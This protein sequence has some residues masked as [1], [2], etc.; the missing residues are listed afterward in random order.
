MPDKKRT[1]PPLLGAHFSVAGG[2]EKA[3]SRAHDLSC[4]ALQIFTKNARSWAEPMPEK[5]T[6]ES[7]QRAISETG[8]V[9]AASHC[10]YLI[11]I[12][13]PEAEKRSRSAASLLAELK[14]SALLGLDAV[15]LHPGS[16]LGR[17][18]DQGL[19]TA[20]QTLKEVRANAP[21]PCP[22][23]LLETTAGTG[24]SIGSR[25]E[26]LAAILERL[27]SSDGTGICLDTSHI[28]AAGYDLR[29][30]QAFDATLAEFDRVIGLDRLFLIHAN[31]SKT[32][33]GS[34][35]DRHEHIGKGE[36]GPTSFAHLMQHPELC[37][38]PKILET[39]KTLN[40][41]DMDPVN[42]GMLLSLAD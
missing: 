6:V 11:N 31:D 14:R 34:K 15:V 4:R 42:L 13:S 25:F 33:L 16:H 36:M 27:T 18:M 22:R 7:F 3:V 5:K 40:E 1:G 9:F 28:F 12:A 26:E 23:L 8:M 2:L 29:T 41:R 32:P 19:Q 24:T 21:A 37:A 10:S 20:A 38:I 17:G 35:K 30:R 39:P